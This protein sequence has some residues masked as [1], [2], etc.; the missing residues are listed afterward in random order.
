MRSRDVTVVLFPAGNST[1]QTTQGGNV[2]QEPSGG[3]GAGIPQLFPIDWADARAA[4]L[5]VE[6][7][8][9]FQAILWALAGDDSLDDARVGQIADRVLQWAHDASLRGAS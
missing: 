4:G 3:G 7:A 6:D 8:R 9:D 1:H 2:G 5:S